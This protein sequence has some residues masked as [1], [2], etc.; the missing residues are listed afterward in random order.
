MNRYSSSVDNPG[1][2]KITYQITKPCQEIFYSEKFEVDKI[3]CFVQSFE[4]AIQGEEY[5][6]EV[7][8]IDSVKGQISILTRDN[9]IMEKFVLFTRKCQTETLEIIIYQLEKK[10]KYKYSKEIKRIKYAIEELG[11]HEIDGVKFTLQMNEE[12]D[13]KY[14][15]HPPSLFPKRYVHLFLDECS[16]KDPDIKNRFKNSFIK[17][18]LNKKKKSKRY[19]DRT[20]VICN[21]DNPKFKHIFHIPLLCLKE[22]IIT[23]K[24]YQLNESSKK[25]FI[26]DISIYLVDLNEC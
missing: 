18:S 21:D 4:N 24:V 7:K 15:E 5:Y 26:D 1:T 20:R 19:S 16:F 25:K 12:P 14:P 9:L 17:V 8:T 23:L 3:T 22:D 11:E 10:G 2:I 6:C 13:A